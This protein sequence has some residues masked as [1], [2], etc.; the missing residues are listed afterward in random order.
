M[1]LTQFGSNAP[2]LDRSVSVIPE[3]GT[4]ILMALGLML[5]ATPPQTRSV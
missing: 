2:L 1:F 4:A 5:L 3:P